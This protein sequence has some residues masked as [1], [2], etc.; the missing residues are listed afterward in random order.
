M[1]YLS[2]MKYYTF[3]DT[4]LD[5]GLNNQVL[6]LL[7]HGGISNYFSSGFYQVYPLQY[8][9]PFTFIV[10]GLYLIYPHPEFL[11]ILQTIFL[12]LTAFPIY[13]IAVKLLGRGMKST[14][15]S[16]SVLGYFPMISA[17]LFDFHFLSLA[18][19]LYMLMVMG[20][21]I[22][23]S[24]IMTFFAL[25]SSMISP[26]VI[27]MVIFF[28]IYAT[29]EDHR[30]GQSRKSYNFLSFNLSKIIIV[31]VLVA[32]LL[33]YRSFNTLYTAGALSGGQ[34]SLFSLLTYD[35]NAKLTFFIFLF[36]SLAFLPFYD[37]SSLFLSIPYFGYVL[38]SNDNANFVVFGL[39]YASLA[40]GPLYFGLIL[41]IAKLSIPGTRSKNKENDQSLPEGRKS[42]TYSTNNLATTKMVVALL[43]A[44]VLFNTVYS[45]FSPVN[46]YVQGGPPQGNQEFYNITHMTASDVF[47]YRVMSLI[48]ENGS[49]LTQNS[50]PQLSGREYIQ[51]P[52]PPSVFVNSIPYNYILIDTDITPAQYLGEVFQIAQSSLAN[53]T[54]GVLAEGIGAL[55]LKRGYTAK[56]VLFVPTVETF[57]AENLWVFSNSI[58]TGYQIHGEESGLAMWYGPYVTLSPGK[59]QVTFNLSSSNVS[60]INT[61][62]LTL[63]V[64][65]NST[66]FASMKIFRNMFLVN[67]TV[68]TF[69]LDFTLSSYTYLV[70]FRGMYYNSSSNLTLYSIVLRQMSAIN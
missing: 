65:S 31:L 29:F 19:L 9:K 37:K 10:T 44:V 47:L 16:I 33:I 1:G 18:P 68:E 4:Y 63:D 57:T 32:V 15:I 53:H 49:V 12:G 2:L 42:T 54:F 17:N 67:G 3:N 39:Q 5:L 45:P 40:I 52:A 25:L 30:A 22:G 64:V 66:T 11:L 60:N 50:I 24:R 69:I 35:I 41:A 55:L 36:G 27:L 8:E 46:K 58:K 7:S 38:L 51:V 21:V 28:L 59:Y 26:I 20:W 23:K 13:K 48:P 70:Q 43:I 62:A 34:L 56:P 14:L 61:S 6:W